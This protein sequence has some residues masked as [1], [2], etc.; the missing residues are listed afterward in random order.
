MV[1]GSLTPLRTQLVPL[2]KWYSA[3][4]CLSLVLPVVFPHT[5]SCFLIL[6]KTAARTVCRCCLPRALSY[7]I[8]AAYTTSVCIC[9]SSST[10]PHSSSDSTLSSSER[11]GY[12]DFSPITLFPA[13]KIPVFSRNLHN[14]PISHWDG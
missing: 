13:D 2:P 9:C 8:T 12:L 11:S 7:A 5:S 10:D 14:F 1:L 4:S 3:S 6:C